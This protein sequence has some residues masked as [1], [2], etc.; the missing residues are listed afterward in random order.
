MQYGVANKTGQPDF[1]TAESIVAAAWE[2]GIRQFDTAQAYGES[3]KVLGHA[4]DSLGKCNDAKIISKIH[5]ETDHNRAES[6]RHAVER[7]LKNLKISKLFALMLHKEALLD[8]WDNGLG[9]RLK[10]MVEAGLVEQLGISLYSPELAISALRSDGISMIQIPSNLLDRRFEE[11]GVF[12]ESER[13]G[14]HVYVRSIF[15]QGLMLM[16]PGR[17]PDKLHFA[18]STLKKVESLA[19]KNGLSRQHLAIGYARMAYSKANII[20]GA[21]TV[22]QVGE[23][24]VSWKSGIPEELPTVIQQS[25]KDVD[26]RILSPNMWML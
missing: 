6:L 26:L 18:A 12:S 2:S 7:S 4:L 9:E 22:E 14:K 20:F 19:K 5:P 1:I 23:N 8:L 17:L 24:I 10:T 16:D 15:L 11:A 21:E 13:Q 3:E 25:F